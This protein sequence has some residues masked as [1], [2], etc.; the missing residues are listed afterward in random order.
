MRDH[1]SFSESDVGDVV[2]DGTMARK[3][4]LGFNVTVPRAETITNATLRLYAIITRDQYAYIGKPIQAFFID[5]LLC[6]VSFLILSIMTNDSPPV[7]LVFVPDRRGASGAG[8]NYCA[9]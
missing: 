5:L 8:G 4:I 6:F 7:I 2:V 1:R 3:H 9:L